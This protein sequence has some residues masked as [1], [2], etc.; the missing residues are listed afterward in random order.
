MTVDVEMPFEELL[1]GS[2]SDCVP[3]IN[4]SLIVSLEGRWSNLLLKAAI[5]A[6]RFWDWDV[7]WSVILNV[8]VEKN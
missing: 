3:K 2:Q 7:C 5:L 1:D 6:L 4:V 8:C